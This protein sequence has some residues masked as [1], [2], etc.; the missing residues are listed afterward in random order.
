[1]SVNN[2]V[3]KCNNNCFLEAGRKIQLGAGESVMML[4]AEEGGDEL[5]HA[6]GFLEFSITPHAQYKNAPACIEIRWQDVLIETLSINLNDQIRIRL[7]IQSFKTPS[8]LKIAFTSKLDISHYGNSYHE[9][10]TSWAIFSEIDFAPHNDQ[11]GQRK[12]LIGAAQFCARSIGLAGDYLDERR[13]ERLLARVQEAIVERRP[14]SVVRLGDGEGRVLGYPAVFTDLEVLTQVL[15][16]HFGPESM[17]RLKQGSPRTWISDA[18]LDLRR[19]LVQAVRHADI[20]GLPISEYFDGYENSATHGQLGFACATNF[21]LAEVKHRNSEDI[22]G[23]NVFQ[24]LA[25][26]GQLYRAA[27]RAARRVHV[28]G[29]WDIREPLLQ[30]LGVDDVQWIQV[31]GHYTWRGEKGL[32]QYPELYKYVESQLRRL[33]NVGGELFLV[34]AGLL[35]KYY[36]SLIKERGGVA[37][38]IGSVMDSWTKRGLPYA[39]RNDKISFEKL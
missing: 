10:N 35:G 3:V 5:R 11:L 29:P 7:P 20:V 38:D 32:G 15:Y 4:Q 14:F 13:T 12:P 36:C 25:S 30:A 6:F 33:E 21:G 39:V 17:H 1:M 16:Y 27:A 31:P 26:R 8:I 9:H 34:G 2:I 37:L 19:L 18:M 24:L 28:V 23:A 22:V